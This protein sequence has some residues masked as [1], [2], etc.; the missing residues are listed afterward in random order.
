MLLSYVRSYLAGR[1]PECIIL[2]VM[3]LLVAVNLFA[4]LGVDIWRQ[5]SM[6]Y[7]T[8]Y[9]D[10]LAEEGRWINYLL[11]RFLQ[12]VPSDLAIA[13]SVFSII[14]FS[15]CIAYKVVV[16]HYFALTFGALCAL[17]PVLAV[18]LE[19]PETIL[20]GFLF[21]AFS[22]YIQTKLSIHYFF[23]LMAILF[24][25]TYSP[26][27]FLMPLLFLNDLNRKRFGVV[28]GCWV[29]AFFLAYLVTNLIVLAATGEFIQIASWRNPNYVTSVSSLL[30]NFQQVLQTIAVHVEKFGSFIKPAAIVLLALIAVVVAARKKSVFA[31]LM[32]LLC[33]F[34][35]YVSAVPI[36]IYVQERTALPALI[37]LMAVFFLSNFTSRKAQLMMMGVMCILAIRMASVGHEGINWFKTHNDTLVRQ[38]AMAIESSPEEINRVYIVANLEESADMFAKIEANLD[39]E[40]IFSEGFNQPSYWV[41]ALRSLGFRQFRPCPDMQGRDCEQVAA[42]YLQR[43]DLPPAKG[44]F[45]SRKLPDGNLLLMIN[46]HPF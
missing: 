23:L 24:F 29:G 22:P 28:L 18:Q 10:K 46:P 8:S 6:Y 1:I 30:E 39:R 14:Y 45:V 26:F 4:L 41:P 12:L 17:I 25:G 38:F 13:L 16:N 27:Y 42:F 34:A 40:N 11:F 36:G 19:W 7:V 15:Y 3:C 31:F 2:A 43:N 20:F 5:D 9:S 44:L 35:I 21:L 37:A 33:V 32:A